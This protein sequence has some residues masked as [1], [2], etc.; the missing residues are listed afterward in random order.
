MGATPVTCV[1]DIYNALGWQPA[2]QEEREIIAHT[3]EEKIILE[4]IKNGTTDGGLLLKASN[5][6]AATFHQHL[7][8]L[9]L[10]GRVRATGGNQWALA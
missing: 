10:T 3:P 2:G 9:E 1:Q 7:T 4:L 6:P 8:M 5:L